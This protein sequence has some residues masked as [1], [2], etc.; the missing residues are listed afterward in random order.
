M[1][2]DNKL[3]LE[4]SQNLN[5]L[6]VEDDE[7]LRDATLK[8]FLNFF[9]SVDVAVDG[10]D[11]L[12]KY[13]T[14]LDEKQTPYDI[15]ITD[16][17]M[18]IMD[19]LGMCE[20]IRNLFYDQ[21]IIFITAFNE[22]EYL[23]K[24]ISLGVS[25]F[26]I[27]PLE[28]N[29]MKHVLYRTAQYV[30]DKKIVRKY[31]D[32][33]E[34]RSML[35]FDIEDAR[36]FSSSKDIVDSLVTNKEQISK[37]WTD[38]KTVQERLKNHLI[39]VEYF[40][41]H[42]G[43]KIIKYFLNVIKGEESIGN[44]PAIF[45]MLDFF[46]NKDLPLEDIFII[47]VEFKNTITSY[48]L[49]RYSFNQK[50]FDDF[51]IILDKNFEGVIINYQKLKGIKKDKKVQLVKPKFDSVALDEVANYSEYVIDNDIYELQ[52]LEEDIDNLAISVVNSSKTTL[53]DYVKLGNNIDKYGQ[54]LYNYP[55]FTELGGYISK[56][57]M[58]LASNSETLFYNPER[59][60]NIS[61]LL[62]GFVN[63]L[64]VWR[65]EIFENNIQDPHFLDS[66]FLS[67]VDTIIMFIEY[68][69]NDTLEDNFDEDIFF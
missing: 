25:G 52:D 18:P 42:Y 64:I 57:G 22:V 24:A 1:N 17:C 45:V 62:E 4:N 23:H 3:I 38:K 60:A 15:V 56:L 65:K 68:D 61:T 29:D 2:I 55:I 51:S 16:I 37:I 7:S 49:K 53:S 50:L 31:Y 48:I 20:R 26:L 54:I 32:Q 33:I 47:C 67:N 66:S 13:K 43:D 30:S 11:G 8:V 34:D 63:D 14:R 19:G 27:K 59:M 39:D 28:I 44:C 5:V 21:A 69:N 6:Y 46:K 36:D 58:E 9:K 10:K 35:S 40:R 12:S 41:T